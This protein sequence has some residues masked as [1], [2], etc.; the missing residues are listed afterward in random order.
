SP[1]GSA[2]GAGQ[3]AMQAA[4]AAAV[5]I[6]VVDDMPIFRDP[7]AASLRLAGYST[8]CAANGREALVAARVNRP[9]AILLDVA[10][11]VMDGISFLRALRAEADASLAKVPVI[12]L[13]AVSDK[14]Y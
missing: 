10:M 12:L 13:T 8:V 14:K 3:G 7:I 1:G 2:A 6:L 5:T 4:G 11:P 9:D